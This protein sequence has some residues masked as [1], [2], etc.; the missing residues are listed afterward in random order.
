MKEGNYKEAL[1]YTKSNYALNPTISNLLNLVDNL[2]RIKN[3][4][5]AIA[6]LQ[7]YI[8]EN[9][10]NYIVCVKLANIYKNLYEINNLA[11]VYEKLGVYNEKFYIMAL[12]LYMEEGDYNRA[13]KLINK[14]NL[15][16]NYLLYIYE[17][18]GA[19]KK[20]A[21]LALYLYTTKGDINYLIKYVID[22]Y[23]VCKDKNSLKDIVNKL[24]FILT[25]VKNSQLYNMLGF[26]LINEDINPKEGLEYVQKALKVEPSNSEYIDSLAWGYYKLGKCKEAWEI[27]KSINSEDEEILRHKK[28]I[29]RCLDDFRENNSKNKREFSKKKK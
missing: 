12:N 23:Q 9:G 10:C 24:K 1:I 3:Y 28:L 19:Y 16:K 26:I 14:Y 7:T 13:I 5:E 25:K 17:E 6:Y 22:C 4:N 8:N 27:I 21:L 15:S 2:L 29:K 20:A 18:K 11:Y